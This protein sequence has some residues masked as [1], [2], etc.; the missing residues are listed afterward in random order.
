MAVTQFTVIKLVAF[1]EIFFVNFTGYLAPA[2]AIDR[3]LVCTQLS[4]TVGIA[5]Y[6]CWTLN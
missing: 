2:Q 5:L 6:L 4:H 3:L 1:V